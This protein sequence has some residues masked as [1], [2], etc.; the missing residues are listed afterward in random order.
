MNTNEAD[1]LLMEWIGELEQ[2][3]R[4]TRAAV[5][6]ARYDPAAHETVNT[7]LAEIRARAAAVPGRQV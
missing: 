1:R 2:L 4:V 3:L 6:L 7:T 5:R